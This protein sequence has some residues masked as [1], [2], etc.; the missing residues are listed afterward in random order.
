MQEITWDD[1]TK[2]ELRVGKIVAAEVFREAEKPAY[3]LRI[4]F[5]KEI[6]MK[7][8]SAQI[9]ALYNPEELL[10]K[11]VVAVVNFPRKQ[12]GP[13]MSEC[14]I[15]GFYNSD[16]AVVLCV[17]EKDIELGSRLL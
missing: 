1:F 14:L 12:I 11:L 7:K 16:G 10:D 8:S 2:V 6:G 9:T 17:P 13:M 4:D 3:K 15:T 5:G